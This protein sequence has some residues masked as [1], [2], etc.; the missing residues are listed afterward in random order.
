[1]KLKAKPFISDDSYTSIFKWNLRKIRLHSRNENGR[2]DVKEECES[3]LEVTF[4]LLW[5]LQL[6]LLLYLLNYDSDGGSESSR[7]LFLPFFSTSYWPFRNGAD[8]GQVLLVGVM[9]GGGGGRVAT[10]ILNCTMR[11]FWRT[12]LLFSLV[13]GSKI[14][15]Q[16]S[17]IVQFDTTGPRPLIQVDTTTSLARPKNVRLRLQS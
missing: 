5:L 1:M 15:S 12:R 17:P 13:I 2:D 9:V 14:V 3:N 11:L 6:L 8:T 7:P 10:V 4:S 16:N